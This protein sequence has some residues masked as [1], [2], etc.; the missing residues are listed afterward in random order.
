MST[1][2]ETATTNNAIGRLFV[3]DLSGGRVFSVRIR[4]APTARSS[5][6]VAAFPT[7]S[8]LTSRGRAHLLDQYGRPQAERRL[9][10]AR[11]LDGRN[12]KT[13]RSRRRHLHAEADSI[14]RRRTASFTGAIAKGCASCAAISTART[15]R[16][17][18]T[19][20]AA[21]RD[22][23]PTP[24]NGVS[25]SPSIPSAGKSTGRKKVRTTRK[26]AASAA[27]TSKSRRARTRPTAAILKC[28]STACRS[29]STWNSISKI[30]SCTG[31][32]AET[33]RA[34]TR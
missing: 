11:D 34:A 5:S 27:R 23:A 6:P 1:L 24:R 22:R 28:C 13:D 10:R 31:P 33:R 7:A 32:T 12:R 25:E 18:S 29:R 14:S 17:W 20:A 4:T 15:S 30:A 2:S 8:W 3:L 19:R 21:M 16:H 9:H 26:Q